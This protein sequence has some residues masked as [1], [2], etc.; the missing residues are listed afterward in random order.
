MAA[1]SSPTTWTKKAAWYA[2]AA[3]AL[4]GALGAARA[5][6]ALDPTSTAWM[7][8][9]GFDMPSDW[10]AIEA[11]ARRPWGVPPGYFQTWNWPVGSTIGLSDGY[12]ALAFF[13]K[14]VYPLLPR[15][16]QWFGWIWVLHHALQAGFGFL[17]ARRLTH[18]NAS[19][20]F[21]ALLLLLT[22]SMLLRAG[23]HV[24]L[25]AHWLI[26]AALWLFFASRT[27]RAPLLVSAWSALLVVAGLTHPTVA[28]MT[29]A[30]LIAG[31]SHAALTRELSNLSRWGATSIAALTGLF[32]GWWASGI[33]FFEDAGLSA[34]GSDRFSIDAAAW[35]EGAGYS[36]FGLD[37]A[38]AQSATIESFAYLGVG[39]MM[40]LVAGLY[41]S[42]GRD[43]FD[44]K[45]Q[46][47]L[48]MIALGAWCF[49]LGTTPRALGS[50]LG[51]FDPGWLDGLYGAFRACGRFAWL[52][53]YI[54]IGAALASVAKLSLRRRRVLLFL[55]V[56]VQLADVRLWSE[57]LVDDAPTAPVTDA[58]WAEAL[59]DARALVTIPP[60]PD[61]RL[62]TSKRDW[63]LI[64]VA[65]EHDLDGV[66]AGKITRAPELTL[67]G[68]ST[69]RVEELASPSSDRAWV[70]SP[71][72]WA[73]F[74]DTLDASLRCQ[75]L[76]ALVVC[77]AVDVAPPGWTSLTARVHAS[78]TSNLTPSAT[79]FVIALT[80]SPLEISV[81]RDGEL[82]W[83]ARGEEACAGRAWREGDE[84]DGEELWASLEVSVCSESTVM[85]VDGW[86]WAID[87]SAQTWV[88]DEYM[89]VRYVDVLERQLSAR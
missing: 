82:I 58:R 12:P 70:G 14:L 88:I 7:M 11:F 35:F 69:H 27:W 81:T 50:S 75:A 46:L 20:F 30:I 53:G 41:V 63:D 23:L 78:R 51:G 45:T 89:S 40:L 52:T 80:R 44:K 6:A 83:T 72:S 74:G 16:A 66:T 36:R 33:F 48:S 68:A 73:R 2:L 31:L 37:L 56:V 10:L 21:G 3:I 9:R 1:P 39:V 4:G 87:T 55:C 49:A 54:M 22:P 34:R 64:R 38:L 61:S 19:G 5:G 13:L 85:A 42:R 65:L 25:S 8:A 32:A 62:G 17:L 18:D 57:P 60:Y 43:D 26:L 84:L 71:A 86:S 59:R 24:A 77:R 29:A 28:T 76:D 15:M 79:D 67:R 47:V